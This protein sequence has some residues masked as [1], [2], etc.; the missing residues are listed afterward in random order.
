MK[1]RA[2]IAGTVFG[3]AALAPAVA[4]AGPNGVYTCTDINGGTIDAADGLPIKEMQIELGLYADGVFGPQTCKAVTNELTEQGMLSGKGGTV[5]IGPRAVQAVLGSKPAEIPTSTI[6]STT[7]ANTTPSP[8]ACP[9]N[10]TSSGEISVAC[11][12]EAVNK[13]RAGGFVDESLARAVKAFQIEAGVSGN[14]QAGF[15]VLG[16]KTYSS[17]MS[18]SGFNTINATAELQNGIFIDLSDQTLKMYKNGSLVVG[19]L[20]STGKDGMETRTGSKK[21]QRTRTDEDGWVTSDL[22]AAGTDP[23][24]YK[25]Y[26]FD[27]GQAIHGTRVESKLGTPASSGCAR[28]DNLVQDTLIAKGMKVGMKVIVQE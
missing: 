26:Y 19:A 22:Q 18:G 13:L 10:V 23:A 12:N 4:E 15:G 25:P 9:T 2:V 8:N 24:M 14:G 3:L 17:I 16:P 27:G 28:T 5:K 7:T 20:V 21:I 11:R 1:T 6:P